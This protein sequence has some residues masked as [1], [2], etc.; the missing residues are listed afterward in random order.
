MAGSP[1]PHNTALVTPI[2]F[3][4]LFGRD[5]HPCDVH[6]ES[7]ALRTARGGRRVGVDYTWSLGF[8]DRT[9]EPSIRLTM[10]A[11]RCGYINVL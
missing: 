8:M 9:R 2:R 11:H 5:P 4:D 6:P 10:L 7:N 3:L 1:T